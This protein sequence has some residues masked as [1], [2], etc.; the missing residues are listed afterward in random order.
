MTGVVAAIA[1][2]DSPRLFNHQVAASN[3]G[4]RLSAGAGP[5]RVAGDPE[6]NDR[7]GSRAHRD[8]S[9]ARPGESSG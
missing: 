9:A 6:V 4:L 5:V 8:R 3:H 1:P 7:D 2:A